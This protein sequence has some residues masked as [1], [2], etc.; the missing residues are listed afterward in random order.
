MLWRESKFTKIIRHL[1]KLQCWNLLMDFWKPHNQFCQ[2][3]GFVSRKIWYCEM[4]GETYR[5]IPDSYLC[6]FALSMQ[7]TPFG[8]HNLSRSLARNKLLSVL[9]WFYMIS[10]RNWIS[11]CQLKWFKIVTFLQILHFGRV[12]DQWFDISGPMVWYIRTNGLISI[13]IFIIGA[14]SVDR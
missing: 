13:I 5:R 1:C 11:K 9:I 3:Q 8:S 14:S 10:T 7:V 4:N 12:Q 6:I 2:K